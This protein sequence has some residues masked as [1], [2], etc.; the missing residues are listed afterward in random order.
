MSYDP[1]VITGSLE[2]VIC[3]H[4]WEQVLTSETSS[5]PKCMGPVVVKKVTAKR[6]K[7]EKRA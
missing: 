4:K 5:C 1:R 2:C 7:K 6:Q 3:H